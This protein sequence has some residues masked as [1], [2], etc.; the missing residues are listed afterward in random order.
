MR[1]ITLAYVFRSE[2]EQ[3][4]LQQNKRGRGEGIWTGPGGKVEDY[5]DSVKDAAIRETREETGI[6][7]HFLE[8]LGDRNTAYRQGGRTLPCVQ[9]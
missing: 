9:V 4:L 5:D 1:D 8:K 6:S 2:G 3:V 7:P